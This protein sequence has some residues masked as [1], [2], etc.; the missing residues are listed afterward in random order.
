MKDHVRRK[1]SFVLCIQSRFIRDR[2]T[3]NTVGMNDHHHHRHL[4]SL[5]LFNSSDW[6]IYSSCISRGKSSF[7]S[8]SSGVPVVRW[9]KESMETVSLTHLSLHRYSRERER[10]RW[11]DRDNG[12]MIMWRRTSCTFTRL[13]SCPHLIFSCRFLPKMGWRGWL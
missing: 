5:F 4:N 8:T 3:K 2:R 13:I 1:L 11:I 10:E 9:D 7:F 6:D 12:G